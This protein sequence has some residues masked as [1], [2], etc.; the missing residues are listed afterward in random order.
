M[1]LNEASEARAIASAELDRT[2]AAF[3]RGGVSRDELNAARAKYQSAL[4]DEAT[5]R[6]ILAAL[7]GVVG[8][9]P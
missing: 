4:A 5:A 3:D 2:Q 7:S 8:S 9:L 1:N 6:A